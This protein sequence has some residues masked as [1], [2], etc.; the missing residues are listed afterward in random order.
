MKLSK[1]LLFFGV[2]PLLMNSCGNGESRI[3][4]LEAERDSL[5]K[6]A[7][8]ANMR[9]DELSGF[10]TDI[11]ECVD[12]VYSQEEIAFTMTDPETGQKLSRNEIR[13]RIIELGNLVDRQKNRIA[14]LADSLKAK[15]DPKEIERL[16]Q[17]VKYL[18]QQLS[19]KEAQLIQLQGELA[20]SKRSI[21]ELRASVASAQAANQKLAGENSA[22]DE[23]VATKSNQLNQGW[24]I[25]KPKKEL[26]QMGILSKGNLL[27][28]GKFNS[29][30]VNVSQCAPVDIRSFTNV[31]LNSKK[32]PI[33]L[34]QAPSSSYTF[35][36]V[37]SGKWE[38]IITDTM[39]FWSLSKIVVI[40]LQ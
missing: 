35:E 4:D 33:L 22:L 23:L 37:G 24:F 11:A 25:A 14:A 7:Y 32:K 38:L 16:T 26:E 17:L 20:S 18:S 5:T 34:S 40:Q 36:E 12:S 2:F 13:N 19:D 9:Y 1:L 10:L 28:K 6:A 30:V 21:S 27:K 29:G 3:K 39:S 15:G 31:K 8:D